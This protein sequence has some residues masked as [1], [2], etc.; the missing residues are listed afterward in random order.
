MY[1]R[2][3]IKTTNNYGKGTSA[4]NEAYIDDS[5]FTGEKRYWSVRKAISTLCSG[6]VKW[7][8]SKKD[9]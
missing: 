1:C 5:Y 7:I 6:D 8:E 9:L 4:E 3:I 2:R